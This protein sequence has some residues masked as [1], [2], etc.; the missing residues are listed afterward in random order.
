MNLP[1]III[2]EEDFSDSDYEKVIKS[3]RKRQDSNHDVKLG[4]SDNK[5]DHRNSTITQSVRESGE[6]HKLADSI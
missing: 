2:H 1:V 4:N 6:K 5:Y 3:K